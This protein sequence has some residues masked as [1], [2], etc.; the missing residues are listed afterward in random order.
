[1]HKRNNFKS[2]FTIA[3]QT[4]FLIFANIHVSNVSNVDVSN[5]EYP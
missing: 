5:V 1:M 4:D 3:H 2:E